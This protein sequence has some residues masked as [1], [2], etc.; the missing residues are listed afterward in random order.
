[1]FN[2]LQYLRHLQ[3]INLSLNNCPYNRTQDTR[4]IH[5]LKE[6]N[7]KALARHIFKSASHTLEVIQLRIRWDNTVHISRWSVA[8]KEERRRLKE[9]QDEQRDLEAPYHSDSDAFWQP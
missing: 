5:Y 6:L 8:Q 9:V 4:V 3:E 1:M 7:C 2:A